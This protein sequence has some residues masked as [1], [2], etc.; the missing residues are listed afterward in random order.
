MR[1]VA[2]WLGCDHALVAPVGG[3]PC[4]WSYNTLTAESL[5]IHRSLLALGVASG[6]T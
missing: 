1:Q 6:A 4:G 2:E 5:F 3:Q